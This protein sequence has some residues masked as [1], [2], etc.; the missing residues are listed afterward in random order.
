MRTSRITSFLTRGIRYNVKALLAY[1]RLLSIVPDRRMKGM[2]AEIILQGHR[3]LD[4]LRAIRF[5]LEGDDRQE[6]PDESVGGKADLET[7]LGG[8]PVTA[9]GEQGPALE[10]TLPDTMDLVETGEDEPLSFVAVEAEPEQAEIVLVDDDA[11]EVRTLPDSPPD[12]LEPG[13][14]PGES[15][16][17]EE[18]QAEIDL[19][20]EDEQLDDSPVAAPKSKQEVIVWKGF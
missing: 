20:P 18:L 8:E 5:Q 16:E 6:G 17:P 11:L 2:I 15:G 4:M 3:Q 19:P 10:Q 7:A 9:S 13:V 12:E 14:F 1:E